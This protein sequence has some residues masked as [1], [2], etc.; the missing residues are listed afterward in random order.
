MLKKIQFLRLLE[1][2]KRSIVKYSDKKQF[3]EL[4]LYSLRYERMIKEINQIKDAYLSGMLATDFNALEITNMLDRNDP[5]EIKNNVL[6]L[7]QFYRE[8]FQQK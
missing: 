3:P 7:N 4:V 6:R 8:N 5:E 2:C 1:K